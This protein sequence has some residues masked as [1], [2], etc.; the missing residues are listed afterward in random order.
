MIHSILYKL[1]GKSYSLKL[2][3]FLLKLF[4]IISSRV[5]NIDNKILKN[6]YSNRK[7][8]IILSGASAVDYL[9]MGVK[10]SEVIRLLEGKINKN[11]ITKIRKYI[12]N[13]IYDGIRGKEFTDGLKQ[14]PVESSSEFVDILMD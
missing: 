12:S 14:Q 4:D 1:L 2:K 8:F 5:S 13:E 6:K 3:N 7:G 10:G 11:T 9:K